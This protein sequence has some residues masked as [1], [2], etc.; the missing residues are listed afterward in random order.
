[1]VALRLLLFVMAAP[2]LAGVLVIVALT[3]PTGF[4][5]F[6]SVSFAVFI[7][8]VLALPV[9]MVLANALRGNKG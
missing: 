9:S 4:D 5:H 7:G 2:T 8:F 1:M 3:T 6:T